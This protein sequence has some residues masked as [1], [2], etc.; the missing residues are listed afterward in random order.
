[1][2]NFM[3]INKK[4]CC[5]VILFNPNIDELKKNV[6][7]IKKSNIFTI[8]V[9]NFSNNRIE[10]KSLGLNVIFLE[11]NFG[12]A[13]AHNI[14]LKKAIKYNYNFAVLL[15]QDSEI[16]EN[17]F[18]EII[19][20]FVQIQNNVD[21][22]IIAVGPVHLDVDSGNLYEIRLKNYQLKNPNDLT[23]RFIKTQY[24]IS[25]GSMISLDKIYEVGLMKDNYFIDYVDN[26]WG[27]RAYKNGFSI[28]VDRSISINHSIGEE[29][30]INGKVK[31]IHSPIRKY[32]MV[33]NSIYLLKERYVPYRYSIQQI[34]FQ[35][36]HAIYLFICLKKN[37]LEY[38][39]YTL[40]G[41]KDGLKIFFR[42]H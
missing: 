21:C 30:I 12:I 25:S 8:F 9:D 5:I 29:C 40:K 6:L 15:D 38:L 14:G 32:Y 36:K 41:L 39:I 34:Y 7:H 4:V 27:F 37:R 28:Y 11:R 23:E 16:K 33:R 26:E 24:I 17:F 3:E 35:I 2:V 42:R 13:T 18:I 22:N 1:M 10:I 31:R 20:S 19:N